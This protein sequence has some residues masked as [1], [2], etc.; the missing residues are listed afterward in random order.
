E[1]DPAVVG[2]DERDVPAAGDRPVAAE[3][4]GV[5]L[6]VD[7]AGLVV[8]QLGAYREGLS[9]LDAVDPDLVQA[10]ALRPD[11]ERPAHLEAAPL[12]V[13]GR[14]GREGARLLTD[15]DGARR[16]ADVHGEAVDV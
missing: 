1:G 16:L 12:P 9:V 4:A 14:D 7:D 3:L 2:A 13:G 8:A 6:H 5:G 15:G 10:D 11:D